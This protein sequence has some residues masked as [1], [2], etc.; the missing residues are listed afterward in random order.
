LTFL[1]PYPLP[2]HPHGWR[3]SCMK[4]NII[5]TLWTHTSNFLCYSK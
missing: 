5:S 1:A 4:Q 3:D 2:P